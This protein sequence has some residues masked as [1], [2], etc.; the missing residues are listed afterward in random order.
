MRQKIVIGTRTSKLA[1]WQVGFVADKIKYAFPHIDIILHPIIT[2]GDKIL[3]MPLARIGGKGLFTQELENSILNHKIDLAVHSLK[4]MPIEL[5]GGL[6]L[7]AVVNRENPKDGLISPRYKSMNKLPHGA[8]VGTSS[9][10]RRAQL[11]YLRP[12]LHISDLRGNVD[13]RLRKLE[14]EELDAIVLAVS[15]LKRLGWQ[16]QVTQEL[17]LELFL[18]AAGQGVLAIEARS[19]DDEVLNML[20]VLHDESTYKAVMSERSFL[21]GVEGGCQVP[22]GVYAKCDRQR[23]S[24]QAVILDAEGKKAIRAK[25][26]GDSLDAVQIGSDL[27]DSMLKE[28]GRELLKISQPKEKM[29]AT[30]EK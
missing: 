14:T 19:Q 27:A 22:I 1:L 16:D 26:E 13:T 8:R 28:G 15:G 10:R 11:L 18:P 9:L 21:K 24:I 30:K 7:G 29:D 4:D 17:P 6:C 20:K 25:A 3:D 23:L 12:D 5:P 2:T